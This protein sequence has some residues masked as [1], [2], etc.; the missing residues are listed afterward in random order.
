MKRGK[1]GQRNEGKRRG[2]DGRYRPPLSQIPWSTLA[3]SCEFS[4]GHLL[5]RSFSRLSVAPL[6]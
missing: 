5:S 6:E 1:E 2:G 3:L 4:V